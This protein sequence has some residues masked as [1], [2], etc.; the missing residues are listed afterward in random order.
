LE[1]QQEAGIS[2]GDYK[3]LK[4]SRAGGTIEWDLHYYLV[5][6]AT[7]GDQDLEETEQGDIEVITLSAEELFEKLKAGEI[8]EGRSADMIWHWLATNNFISLTNKS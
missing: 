3:L 6:G 8:Q 4:V 7:M 2:G 1:G 5:T